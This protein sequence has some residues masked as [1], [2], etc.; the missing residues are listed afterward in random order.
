[1]SRPVGAM[2]GCHVVQAI[3]P[4]Y[5]INARQTHNGVRLQESTIVARKCLPLQEGEHEEMTDQKPEI[6][7]V[8][9][10]ISLPVVHVPLHLH[11]TPGF[12]RRDYSSQLLLAKNESDSLLCNGLHHPR[13]RRQP[14]PL[15]ILPPRERPVPFKGSCKHQGAASV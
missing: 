1:M 5:L 4:W 9:N 15:K 8:R 3:A 14:R 2:W 10:S 7:Q 11:L 6:E 13:H 12:S